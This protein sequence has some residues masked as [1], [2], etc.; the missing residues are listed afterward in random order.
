MNAL[1]DLVPKGA[2]QKGLA[3]FDFDG[4]ITTGDS[5]MAMIRSEL[6]DLRVFLGFIRWF[7]WLLG[8]LIG[9]VDRTAIKN[10]ILGWAF[11]GWHRDTIEAK[12]T[13]FSLHILPGYVREDAWNRLME[14]QQRGDQICVVTASPEVWIKPWCEQ[15]GFT[16]IGSKLAYDAEGRFTGVLEGANCHGPEKVRRIQEVIQL[17]GYAIRYAYG[18]TKGDLPMLAL[19]QHRGYKAFRSG[20]SKRN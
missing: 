14:H 8:Y 1:P 16:C 13:H 19:A 3:L 12:S 11:G 10:H 2:N 4:T 18:D 17:D 6:G 9:I 15:H 20:P 5:F 7:P